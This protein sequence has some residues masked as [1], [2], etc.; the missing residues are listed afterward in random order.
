MLFVNRS[1]CGYVKILFCWLFFSLTGFLLTLEL[2]LSSSL[3]SLP[4]WMVACLF[5]SLWS[6]LSITCWI[7][8]GLLWRLGQYR[9]GMCRLFY[10][11][12]GFSV[13]RPSNLDSRALSF[14][15]TVESRSSWKL[16]FRNSKLKSCFEIS[17]TLFTTFAFTVLCSRPSCFVDG[18][19]P[20]YLVFIRSAWKISDFLIDLSLK[21]LVCTRTFNNRFYQSLDLA[22]SPVIAHLTSYVFY[23]NLCIEQKMLA[24][25]N[26][27]TNLI[28]AYLL[29]Y[30]YCA[31]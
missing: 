2:L 15:I 11:P 25:E 24:H 19:Q 13:E 9:V 6:C 5:L 31:V 16:D 29:W 8:L 17:N 4:F 30:R 22:I 12:S 14:T 21:L 23:T 7:R 10:H 26:C 1:I 18:D 20:S 3:S 27:I 28:N